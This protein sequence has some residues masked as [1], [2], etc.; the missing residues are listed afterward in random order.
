MTVPS[1]GDVAAF[2]SGGGGGVGLASTVNLGLSASQVNV[3]GGS[4]REGAVSQLALPVLPEAVVVPGAAA[5]ASSDET[6]AAPSDTA[7]HGGEEGGLDLAPPSHAASAS[8][9]DH[10]PQD[11]AATE[12]KP[13]F[14][15]AHDSAREEKK[16]D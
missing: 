16:G 9:P 8:A 4:P 7:E 14:G 5:A 10:A 3:G 13:A 11:A 2:S 15:V 6:T 12:P 1:F